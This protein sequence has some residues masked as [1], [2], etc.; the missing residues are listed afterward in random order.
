MGW[1]RDNRKNFRKERMGMSIFLG[2]ISFSLGFLSIALAL[3]VWKKHMEKPS[4]LYQIASIILVV[5]G[6][7]V[8]ACSGY[9]SLKYHFVG[10]GYGRGFRHS[11][12]GF[13]REGRENGEWRRNGR[14]RYKEYRHKRKRFRSER[15]HQNNEKSQQER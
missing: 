2:L 3:I 12:M 14:Y 6:I 5:G 9:Y 4:S 1:E 7:C 8:T 10:H 13:E 15:K 11:M